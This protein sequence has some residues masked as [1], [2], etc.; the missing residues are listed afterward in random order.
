MPHLSDS[1]WAT[2]VPMS[3]PRPGLDGDLRADVAVVGGGFTG[4]WTAYYLKQTRPDLDVVVIERERVGY[5]ASGRNG[6]WLGGAI[7]G[8][9]THLVRRYGRASVL[10]FQQAIWSGV[11]E[12]LERLEAEGIDADQTKG[13]TLRVATTAAQAARLAASVDADHAFGLA[14]SDVRLIAPDE[15]SGRVRVAGARA[16]TFTPHAAR[17]H[18][19][20]LV[21]GLAAA[22]ERLGVRILE[23]TAATRLEPGKVVCENGTVAARYVV[24]ATEGYTAGLPGQRRSW[25]PMNSSM[26]VTE[27]LPDAARA[28]I[29]WERAETLSD[30]AHS[31]VYLQR[32]ADGRIAIGGRGDPY[33]YASR[34]DRSDHTPERTIRWLTA[35][36]HRLFPATRD[37][38]VAHGWSGILGVPRDWCASVGLDPSTGLAWAGGYVGHGVTSANLA[39]RTLRDLILGEESDLL[40]MPWVNHRVRH[41]EPEPLRWAGVHSMYALYRTADRSE[42]RRGTGATSS[43]AKVA[44]RISGRQ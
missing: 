11:D 27:P 24:R 35:E 3:V 43:I 20:K 38:P 26:I 28:E 23:T 33:R 29:G 5:G 10:R 40:A 12:V 17:V 30:V 1:F 19:G 9:R 16:A 41:W 8:E 44:D 2:Q 15:L 22:V 37:V 21:V 34:T 25:L 42:A 7:P 13:G 6:G 31:Y 39:G 4:L 18:P 14:E 36:L 32:T